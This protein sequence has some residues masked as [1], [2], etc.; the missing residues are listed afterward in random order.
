M[1][2][3]WQ[4]IKL[5]LS[6]VYWP[7]MAVGNFLITFNHWV[8]FLPLLDKVFANFVSIQIL[9][10]QLINYKLFLSIK[11]IEIKKE[12]LTKHF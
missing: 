12:Y 5:N 3:K 6:S 1:H 9:F 10:G 4:F 2:Q 11:S 7:T 8:V